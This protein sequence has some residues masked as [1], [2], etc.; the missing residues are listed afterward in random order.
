M[1]RIRLTLGSNFS[2]P[3]TENVEDAWFFLLHFSF[4]ICS[5]F[6]SAIAAPRVSSGRGGAAYL[7]LIPFSL[8]TGQPAIDA[9]FVALWGAFGVSLME[10]RCSFTA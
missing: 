2:R 3:C 1:F 7:R 4:C 9:H 10:L 8:G 6:S 5:D